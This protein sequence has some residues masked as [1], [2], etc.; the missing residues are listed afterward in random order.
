MVDGGWWVVGGGWWVVGGR[1][2]GVASRVAAAA[3]RSLRRSA[4]LSLALPSHERSVSA[5]AGRGCM[6][7]ACRW[8]AACWWYRWG[9]RV[10]ERIDAECVSL[11]PSMSCA[12]RIDGC[13]SCSFSSGPMPLALVC[14]AVDTRTRQSKRGRRV[15]TR[16]SIY[17]RVLHDTLLVLIRRIHVI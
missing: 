4:L 17:N 12:K 8:H 14:P 5:S 3:K 10:P 6:S 15:T 9:E 2:L 11:P 13:R 16:A 7:V 1:W